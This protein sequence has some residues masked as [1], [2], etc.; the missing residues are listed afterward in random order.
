[1]WLKRNAFLVLG[2]TFVV[3]ASAVYGLISNNSNEEYEAAVFRSPTGAQMY[4]SPSGPT[5][6][7][8]RPTSSSASSTNSGCPNEEQRCYMPGA[9]CN[10]YDPITRTTIYGR[11]SES[12]RC[13]E[14]LCGNGKIDY[15]DE[16]ETW[17]PKECPNG[18][19][20]VTNP[21]GCK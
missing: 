12:C 10:Y 13:I 19:T 14:D 16:C 11:C 3:L 1:M 8:M 18:K 21:A 5:G 15:G 4:G 6:A 2:I 9:G 20:C 17:P 7:S